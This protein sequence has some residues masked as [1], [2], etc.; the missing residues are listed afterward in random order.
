MK[1]FHNSR[2]AAAN[3]PAPPTKI[4]RTP[5][6][7]APKSPRCIPIQPSDACN[8]TPTPVEI[9]MPLIDY[10]AIRNPRKHLKTNTR[11]QF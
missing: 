1:S 8:S 11:H 10:S 2:D 5:S 6:A 4:H 3:A 9:R 7:S